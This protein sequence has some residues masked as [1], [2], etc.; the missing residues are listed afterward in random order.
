MSADYSLRNEKGEAALLYAALYGYSET[1]KTLIKAGASPCIKNNE[2]KSILQLA[3]DRE[4]T[5]VV[6]ILEKYCK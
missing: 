2:G 5:E 6:K 4:N 3:Q 1:V